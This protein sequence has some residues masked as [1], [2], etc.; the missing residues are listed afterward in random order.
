MP[1][2]D[3][4]NYGGETVTA[5]LGAELTPPSGALKGHRIGMEVGLPAY[6]KVNGVQL[7][8]DWSAMV[9]WRKAF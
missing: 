7:R 6:Q 4:A 8:R 3:P 5:Y 1:G 2:S 9:S